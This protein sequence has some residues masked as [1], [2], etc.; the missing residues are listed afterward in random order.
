MCSQS[1]T[2]FRLFYLFC[3]SLSTGYLPLVLMF[4]GSTSLLD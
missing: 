4:K 1:L 2:E 3:L